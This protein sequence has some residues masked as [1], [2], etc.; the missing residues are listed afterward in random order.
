MAIHKITSSLP[1]DALHLRSM[2]VR[3]E[4]SRPFEYT[5]DLLSDENDIDP[6]K[7]LG[8]SM[9]V[10]I[11]CPGK[12]TRN[13]NGLVS[14][15]T[16]HGRYGGGYVQYR[17]ILRPWFWFLSHTLDCRIFQ[18]KTVPEIFKYVCKD[19][20]NFS[21]FSDK[22]SRQY[23]KRDYCVQ[24]RES[25]FDFLSRLLEQEGIY[26]FFDHTA[27][28]HTL[29]LADAYSSHKK[30]INGPKIPF[31]APG[32]ARADLEHV[33]SWQVQHELH[34]TAYT[35]DDYDF[36]KPKAKL[37]TKSQVSRQHGQAKFKAY[38]YPGLYLETKDGEQYAKNRIEELQ[39]KHQRV[40]GTSDHHGVRVGDL[41]EL[42]EHPR[43]AENAE[44]LIQATEIEIESAEIEQF[45]QDAENRFDVRLVAFPSKTPYRPTRLTPKPVVHGPQTA[46]VVGKK[47]EDIWTDKYGRIKVQFHWDREGKSDEKSSCWIR[48]AQ[49]WAGES[50]GGMHIPRMGQEVVVE[51]LEG[52]PDRPLV[53]SRVYNEDQKV[54]YT[55]PDNQTQSGIKSRSTKQGSAD[56]FNELR[57]EDKK[58]EEEIYFHAEKDFQR[59]VENNDTLKVG[60]DKKDKGDQVVE[61]FNNQKL[62]IG[63]GEASDGSQTIAIKKDQKTELKEG[64][65]TVTV[66]KDQKTEL[67]TGDH[68]LKVTAGASTIQAAKKITLKVGG[69]SIVI[70]PAKITIKAPQIAVQGDTSVAIKG[71][72]TNIEGSGMLVQKGGIVKVN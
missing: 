60:F 13:F 30:I 59:I 18:E 54:P 29:V 19:L 68:T 34:T 31:R 57:F 3:E 50:W 38:D 35:L 46:V 16:Y 6:N 62:T 14:H 5:V 36:T 72:N 47:G 48:V 42:S 24:Y 44:Y 71:L 20:N 63:D 51:F 22:L 12:Q 23:A 25:A 1:T 39:S 8:K 64:S 49:L 41:F 70:E 21:D 55:L 37:E 7:L 4:L 11:E 32:E 17:A 69:S 43:A 58:D 9:T 52:D 26:Y 56:S 67:K 10:G 40:S 15:F 33:S 28:E 53:T 45:R 61:I 27:S 2:L 65:Q 66:Q